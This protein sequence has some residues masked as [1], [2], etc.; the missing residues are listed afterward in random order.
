MG[1]LPDTQNCGLCMRRE[2][3]GRFPHHWLQRKP[4]VSDPGMHHGT[5]VTHVPWCMSGSL[6]R[7]GGE[8]VPGIPGA[9]ATQNFTYLVRGP[10]IDGLVQDCGNSSPLAIGLR[11]SCTKPSIY[12]V[13]HCKPVISV[14][15]IE[16]DD[17]H[18]DV[19]TWKYFPHYSPLVREI[20]Q[21]PVVS[22]IKRTNNAKTLR[23]I[24]CWPQML[25]NK[26]L[27]CRWFETPWRSNY[28]TF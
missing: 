16:S 18:G 21:L 4:L 10:C 9:C 14:I 7:G 1:L 5:C 24:L 20:H 8:N 17:I 15:G 27:S 13:K 6:T 25:L 2:C 12:L 22:L 23:F 3:R 19:M 28:F 26:H 11:Q